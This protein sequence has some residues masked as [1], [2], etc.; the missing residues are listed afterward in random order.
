MKLGARR[1]VSSNYH[2]IKII[3]EVQGPS[4]PRLLAGGP[5]GLLT[6]SIAPL[7]RSGRVTQAMLIAQCVSLW[8]VCQSWIVCQPLDSLLACGQCVSLWIVCQS[9]DNVLVCGQCVS[10]WIVCQPLNSV[11][12]TGQCVSRFFHYAAAGGGRGGGITYSR[13]QDAQKLQKQ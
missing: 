7:G 6:S 5:L 8:T 11:L 4:W 2:T 12:A 10:L 1:Y 9:L 3:L 13:S